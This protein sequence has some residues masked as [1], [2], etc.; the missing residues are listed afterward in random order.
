MIET[1][2]IRERGATPR[3]LRKAHNAAAKEAW[4]DAGEHWFGEIRPKH[5]TPEGAREYGYHKRKG[6]NQSGARFDRSYTGRKL[7]KFGH[8]NPLEYSGESKRRT[9]QGRVSATSRG[10]R[11][12]M[13][14]PALNFKHPKSRIVMRAELAAISRGDAEDVGR[15]FDR[16]YDRGL[17][18]FN[19]T[20]TTRVA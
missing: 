5:F 7:K 8:T 14:A 9:E 2:V 12:V 20:T 10:A 18:Q 11:V 1:I 17:K 19:E 4:P 6:E 15:V 3:K 16:S 13:N